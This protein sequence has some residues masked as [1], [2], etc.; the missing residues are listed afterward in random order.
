M[1]PSDRGLQERALLRLLGTRLD[2]SQG[3]AGRFYVYPDDSYHDPRWRL[4]DLV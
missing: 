2:V 1:R 3:Y 4:V